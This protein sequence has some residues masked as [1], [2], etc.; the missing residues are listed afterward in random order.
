[1]SVLLKFR[2]GDF[3]FTADVEAM[4]Y[5][6]KVPPTDRK[7]LRLLWWDD[8]DI[9][10]PPSTFRMTVHPFGACSS[11]SIANHVLQKVIVEEYG[12][13]AYRHNFYVDDCLRA[14]QNE[15]E[16]A[17]NAA[18]LVTACA[19]GGF[20]LTKFVSNRLLPIVRAC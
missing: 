7:W 20:S 2:E 8:G 19:R 10:K 18:E 14:G 17:E 4:Y 16:L 11:A 5:Q 1:M 6:V 9:S 3:A 12:T 15:Y 13:E